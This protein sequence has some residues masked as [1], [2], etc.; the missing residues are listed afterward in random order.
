MSP[1]CQGTGR[2]LLSVGTAKGLLFC[3]Y[4]DSALAIWPYDLRLLV[5]PIAVAAPYFVALEFQRSALRR[6]GALR[7][8]DRHLVVCGA[9]LTFRYLNLLVESHPTRHAG[10]AIN[11]RLVVAARGG[12]PEGATP[13]I[14]AVINRIG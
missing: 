12:G 14:L 3:V 10:Y 13:V 7:S 4:S 8:L 11:Q 9:S 5:L 6:G 1:V 2:K